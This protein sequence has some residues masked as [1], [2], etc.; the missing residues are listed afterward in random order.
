[1]LAF[2]FI[3]DEKVK[4]KIL[5]TGLGLFIARKVVEAHKGKLWAESDGEGKGSQF[6]VEMKV[7]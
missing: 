7:L 5:G 4:N 3:R 2:L 1:L 6:F